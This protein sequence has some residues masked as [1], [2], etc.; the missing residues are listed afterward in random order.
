MQGNL[1]TVD[2]YVRAYAVRKGAADS[3]LNLWTSQ[4]CLDETVLR[5]TVWALGS[6]L[7]GTVRPWSPVVVAAAE[8]VVAEAQTGWVDSRA[9]MEGGR[10]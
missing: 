2:S 8:V 3:L 9:V 7:Q 4:L 5:T 10:N 6:L 1:V